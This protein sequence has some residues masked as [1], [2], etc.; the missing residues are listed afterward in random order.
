MRLAGRIFIF[1][2]IFCGII[3]TTWC[4]GGVVTLAS[5]KPPTPEKFIK[6]AWC[7]GGVVTQ[8]SAK[9][10]T[11]VQFRSAP[12]HQKSPLRAYFNTS[13]RGP[14]D[15]TRTHNP[16]RERILSP[17]RIPIPPLGDLR[18]SWRRR[19]ELNRCTRFCRPLRNHSA[20][21]PCCL[22]ISYM[23]EI[24]NALRI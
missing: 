17:P 18:F 7:C 14:R 4:C 20:T 19:P 24:K 13:F 1:S 23:C 8:R 15:G 22:I 5:V 12:P 11:P 9:P 2:L 21:A 6:I 16:E 3:I 10:R